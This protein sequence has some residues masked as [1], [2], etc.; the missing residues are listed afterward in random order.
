MII[1]TVIVDAKWTKLTYYR[2]VNMSRYLQHLEKGNE[3]FEKCIHS[4]NGQWCGFDSYPIID[5]LNCKNYKEKEYGQ[6]AQT[7]G[8]C[9]A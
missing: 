5:C 4:H 3:L 6:D 7:V 8:G 9:Y 1:H 2:G